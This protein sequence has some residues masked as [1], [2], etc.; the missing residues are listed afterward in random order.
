LQQSAPHV[1]AVECTTCSC[2]GVHHT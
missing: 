1:A 2:R